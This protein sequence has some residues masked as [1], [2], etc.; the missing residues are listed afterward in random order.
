MNEF[1]TG[2]SSWVVARSSGLG[3]VGEV[4]LRRCRRQCDSGDRTWSRQ[5]LTDS[6]FQG[7]GYRRPNEAVSRKGGTGHRQKSLNRSGANSV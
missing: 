3:D 6:L 2:C 4:T 5:S 7:E 1:A